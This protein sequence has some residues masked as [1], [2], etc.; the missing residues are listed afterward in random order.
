M[1]ILVS[2]QDVPRLA[3]SPELIGPW[4]AVEPWFEARYLITSWSWVEY[5][6]ATNLLG[7]MNLCMQQ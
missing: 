6:P 1:S 2:E 5:S 3:V 7:C 4:G